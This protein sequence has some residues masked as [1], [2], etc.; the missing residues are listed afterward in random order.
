MI[1]CVGD[2]APVNFVGK[3]LG[4]IKGSDA[5]VYDFAALSKGR[6]D[7]QMR[8]TDWFPFLDL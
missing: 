7:K 8:T 4:N 5:S 1:R 6:F 2:G 3:R